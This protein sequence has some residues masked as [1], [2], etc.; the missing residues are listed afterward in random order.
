MKGNSTSAFMNKSTAQDKSGNRPIMGSSEPCFGSWISRRGQWGYLAGYQEE[1]GEWDYVAL[2]QKTEGKILQQKCVCV[3][4]ESKL[5][6]SV[7]DGSCKRHISISPDHERGCLI[8]T[9]L[10][11]NR[12]LVTYLLIEAFQYSMDPQQ[13]GKVAK[14]FQH[15]IK[16][17]W[18]VL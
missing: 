8:I 3:V 5:K 16:F 10:K 7:K 11:W 4:P 9:D 1:L 14:Y 6:G 2:Q 15:L 17:G 12:E 13:A 18:D